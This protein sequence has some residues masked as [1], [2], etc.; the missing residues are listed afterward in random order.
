MRGRLAVCKLRAG[1]SAYTALSSTDHGSEPSVFSL[2]NRRAKKR[3]HGPR[4]WVSPHSIGF[5]EIKIHQN[6]A[7]RLTGISM[8]ISVRLP[9]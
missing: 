7:P 4:S 1:N 5:Y 3:R 9:A 8:D 2:R 6:S